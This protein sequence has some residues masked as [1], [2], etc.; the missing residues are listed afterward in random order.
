MK[1]KILIVEDNKDLLESMEILLSEHFTVQ[2]A[3]D[4]AD[5]L[6][7]LKEFR[8]DLI[9]SDIMMPRLDG[10][11]LLKSIKEMSDLKN[12][13]IILLTALGQDENLIMGYDKGADDYLVKPIR[14]QV[15]ISRINNL[16]RK[17]EYLDKIYSTDLEIK[18]S[19]PV[20]DPI[21]AMLDSL[22]IKKYKFKHF[23]IPDLADEM[24]LSYSKLENLV[25]EKAGMTPVKYINEIKLVKA[26]ELLESTQMPIKEIAFHLGFK[27]LS[28]FGKCYKTKY[29]VTPSLK[30]LKNGA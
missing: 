21:L 8:P 22:I 7:K 26:K 1:K 29:G 3:I 10:F 6:E 14:T 11:G 2:T 13:P 12:I 19:L 18:T 9:V 5:G 20:K 30:N 23:S 25:K 24:G 28:Y 17:Q 15:L 16:L 27:S 4:G